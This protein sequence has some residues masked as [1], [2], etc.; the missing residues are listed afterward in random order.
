M[1]SV[2]PEGLAATDGSLGA[3]MGTN[4]IPKTPCPSSLFPSSPFS[5]PVHTMQSQR[6]Q[7]GVTRIKSSLLYLLLNK[8]RAL[9][10]ILPLKN[11]FVI[12][13]KFFA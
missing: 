2:Q 1:E 8:T 4:N 5:S 3:A 13:Y 12:V 7:L 11:Q 10:H 6:K 9:S